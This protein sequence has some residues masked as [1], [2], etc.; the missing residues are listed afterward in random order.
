MEILVGALVVLT[1]ASLALAAYTGHRASVAQGIAMRALDRVSD[2]SLEDRVDILPN[3]Q[4]RVCGIRRG[5][6]IRVVFLGEPD[7]N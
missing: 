6:Y 5:G 7:K 1:V 4:V 2:M 3:G